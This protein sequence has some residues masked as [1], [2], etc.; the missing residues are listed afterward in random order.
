M[1]PTT[2]LSRVG[3]CCLLAILPA[4]LYKVVHRLTGEPINYTSKT[5]IILGGLGLFGGIFGFALLGI[6]TIRS[7]FRE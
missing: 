7:A 2:K 5:V 6:A 3:Y 4:I 1:V